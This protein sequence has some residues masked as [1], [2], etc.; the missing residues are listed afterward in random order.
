ML[1]FQCR[2]RQYKVSSTAIFLDLSS[3]R[4]VSA[5]N[6]RSRSLKTAAKT[7]VALNQPSAPDGLIYLYIPTFIKQSGDGFPRTLRKQ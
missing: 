2:S 4:L 6:P 7:D 1:W 5:L 3:V